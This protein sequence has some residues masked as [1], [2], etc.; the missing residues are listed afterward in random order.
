MKKIGAAIRNFFLPPADAKTFTRILPLF[1]IVILMLVLFVGATTA[2]ESSNSTSFCGTTCHTMPPQYTTHQFSPHT[3]VSCDDCHMGRDV[4]GV[5]IPRKI[6]YSWQTGSAM[7]LGTYKYP[8]VAKNMAPAREACENCHKPEYFTSDTLREIRHYSDDEANTPVSTFLSI[9]TGGGTKREGLGYG[10]HWHIENPVYYYATDKEEQTIPYVYVQNADGSKTEYADVESGFDPATVKQSDLKQMDCITCHNR[11]A[12]DFKSPTVIADDLMSRGLVSSTIPDAKKKAVEVLSAQYTSDQQAMDGIAAFETYYQQQKADFYT[13]N[14][15]MVKTAVASLQE[16]W[17]SNFF[18]DQKADWQDHP[19]NLGH[20]ESAGCFRCHDGKHLTATKES[21]RLECNL[22]HSIPAVASPASLGTSLNLT[23]G[24]EPESHQNTNW[25]A[26]HRDVY[27]ET[28]AGCHTTDDAGGVSNTSFCS[29]SACH[30]SSWNYAGFDAPKLRETLMEQVALMA[31]PT[32]APTPTAIPD[33]NGSGNIEPTATA[34]QAAAPAQPAGP[35]TYATLQDT[36]KKKC[37]SC[38]GASAM[39]G[40]N[41]TTYETLMK[42]SEDGPVV[43]AGDPDNSKLVQVQSAT[44]KHFGQFSADELAQVIEW[45]KGGA[46][47]K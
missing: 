16:A 19:N 20:E 35:V 30:G 6:K 37:G 5:M 3:N 32:T 38:H 13:T 43:V 44:K 2:W 23:K 9:K 8:I 21:V 12:H 29:N 47:E 34:T 40:L 42:G 46:L 1:V 22:C 28:C 4:L 31:T 11:T 25:I 33:D 10:I 17:K 39:K 18:L 41:V 7:V 15:D 24:F 27:D 14:T 45:I 26:L 36:F